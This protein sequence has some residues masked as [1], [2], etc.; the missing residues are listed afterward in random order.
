RPSLAALLREGRIERISAD[1]RAAR[2]KL[3]ESKRHLD[4]AAAIS[5]SDPAGAYALAYDAAR[6]ALDAH[7]LAKGYRVSK[8]R[9]GSHEA[10]G[11]YGEAAM[12]RVEEMNDFDRIRRNRNRS[13]NRKWAR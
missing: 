11:L 2:T 12:P 8:G 1:I 3:A 10:T 7:M 5:K 4:S 13:E 9:L 6:K